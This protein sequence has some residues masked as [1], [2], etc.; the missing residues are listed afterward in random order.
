[1]LSVHSKLLR[2]TFSPNLYDL[3][4]L[5]Y[6]VAKFVTN[7]DSHVSIFN[8]IVDQIDGFAAMGNNQS[9]IL[10][11]ST[12]NDWLWNEVQHL[13]FLTVITYQANCC[14][15]SDSLSALYKIQHEITTQITI[16]NFTWIWAVTNNF[17]V[18]SCDVNQWGISNVDCS[19]E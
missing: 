10:I 1:M 4:I 17:N 15:D 12:C 11:I 5:I 7:W 9:R 3:S 18:I 14:Y 2:N 8:D 13:F 6:W 19:F 16:Q